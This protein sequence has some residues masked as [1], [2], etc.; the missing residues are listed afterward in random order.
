M[1]DLA[2]FLIRRMAQQLSQSANVVRSHRVKPIEQKAREQGFNKGVLVV[3]PF[4]SGEV[5]ELA[6]H[7]PYLFHCH[8]EL[9]HSA[10]KVVRL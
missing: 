2:Q 1:Y 5:I 3:I 6:L 8:P 4:Q 7:F 10:V 9:L